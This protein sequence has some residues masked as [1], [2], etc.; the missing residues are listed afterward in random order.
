MQSVGIISDN[1]PRN[2]RV[3]AHVS[4]CSLCTIAHVSLCTRVTMHTCH[5][6]MHT[7]H[8]TMHTCHYAHVSLYTRVCY[9]SAGRGSHLAI[10]GSPRGFLLLLRSYL[11]Q[12]SI[13]ARHHHHHHHQHH[14]PTQQPARCCTQ[15]PRQN[16]KHS[17][18]KSHDNKRRL[19]NHCGNSF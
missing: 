12:F 19:M 9:G 5:Y 1:C 16:I 3:T 7:C 11:G 14:P 18:N 2:A 8:Y 13:A 6:T 10:S 15:I 4:L 17:S